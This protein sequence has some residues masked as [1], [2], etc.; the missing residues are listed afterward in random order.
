MLALG[1]IS[2]AIS[3]GLL[4]VV[5][6]CGAWVGEATLRAQVQREIEA[7]SERYA[8]ELQADISRSLNNAFGSLRALS[9][10]IGK[11]SDLTTDEFAL[12]AGLFVESS[13]VITALVAAPAGA[14]AYAYP[15]DQDP[16][17]RFMP[18]ARL[19]LGKGTAARTARLAVPDDH[20][21]IA[22]LPVQTGDSGGVQRDWGFVAAVLDR[23]RLLPSTE[24]GAV[25]PAI[26]VALPDG[27]QV[28]HT[29]V[30]L[31]GGSE[32]YRSAA[33]RF[34]IPSPFGLL[35]VAVHPP[36]PG[37][38]SFTNRARG[39]P[40]ALAVILGL[41]TIAAAL[42]HRN[43]SRATRLA[44]AATEGAETR[45]RLLFDNANDAVFMNDATTFDILDA[46]LQ[47]ERY[48]GYSREELL[49]LK[50]SDLYADDH[51]TTP[52]AVVARISE[53]HSTIFVAEHRRRDGS[54]VPV[55]VSTRLIPDPHK[56]LLISVVR[57]ITDRRQSD[58][59]LRRSEQ[60]LINS[61]E[62]ISEGFVLWDRND[63]LQIFNK[64]VV[65]LMPSLDG[66]L[67]VGLRFDAMQRKIVENN[68][69]NEDTGVD[70]WLAERDRMRA[71]GGR[72]IE[73]KTREG[74]WIRLNENHTPD[75][76]TVG[77]YQDI[78]RIKQAEQ[79]IRYRAD[80]DAVTTLPNRAN[81]MLQ[82]NALVRLAQ[83][84]QT[85]SALLFID[86]DRFKNINDTLGHEVGDK[87]LRE[88]GSRILAS[89]RSTDT[90]A[91]FGGDEFT[92]ILRDIDDEM[93]AARI[94]EEIIT[95]LSAAHHFD[96]QAVYVSASIGITLCPADAEDSETLLRNADMAMYQAKARGR[97][98]YQFFTN[99][100]TEQAKR[101]VEL[102]N[103]L[104]DSLANQQF[105]MHYQPVFN[106]AN[107]KLLGAEA[108]LRWQHP[109]RGLVLPADFVQ[110]AE[111]TK[112]INAIGAWVLRAACAD[113]RNWR[114]SADAL[115]T[116]VSIN[117]SSGQ[118]FNGFDAAYIS[119]V[120]REFDFPPEQ[121]ILEITESI[122]IDDDQ[123][124]AAILNAIR[125]LGVSIALDD[126]GTGYSALGYLRRFPVSMIKIDRSFIN[127]MKSGATAVRLVESI[128]A[129]A[130]ALY[131]EVVAEGV[132]THMQAN[133][134][135]NMGC[136]AG[137]GYLFGREI[138]APDFADQ[139]GA[140]ASPRPIVVYPTLNERNANDGRA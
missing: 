128:V 68:L 131:I 66:I 49:Q 67:K 12:T 57:D 71:E 130:N 122:L 113:S 55:E 38:R 52:A 54:L 33:L 50:V 4:L 103:D 76:Y 24:I 34:E 69:V 102:E 117:V 74:R 80:F 13:D 139:Y 36:Q 135:L 70:N 105:L 88:A 35:Q 120:L 42:T 40:T 22:T 11:D 83:R 133:L 96:G 28:S 98:T 53:S 126:F 41:L 100:L 92:V 18:D 73:F 116:R 48:L 85:L 27:S 79:H 93:N 101:F 78:T 47:A 5:L 58:A 45:F 140:I 6:A 20:T 89:I 97:G 107:G 111:E 23:R 104:R 32:V 95:K 72:D 121:L 10:V 125:D 123:R 87:L 25:M 31:L 119:S 127:D 14:V 94:S 15:T 110:V 39:A 7:A 29:G 65:E 137:Q 108:L 91:R 75:G 60:D 16:E 1:N 9:L 59:A 62:S 124:V 112:L 134:L 64:R 82:L 43:Q 19:P 106:M 99:K 51:A 129:M 77:V 90:M 132:E 61:I 114:Q 63:R 30:F 26:A 86:L 44:R 109:Q 56:P 81:F 17:H 21:V 138:A 115:S 136:T 37:K 84:S 3:T 8:A 2:A 118:F 46:N